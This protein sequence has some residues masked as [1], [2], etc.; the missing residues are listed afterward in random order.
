MPGAASNASS[1]IPSTSTVHIPGIGT[2]QVKL[3]FSRHLVLVKEI[4]KIE[5]QIKNVFILL[6][7]IF[8]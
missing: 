8:L 1:G 4:G 7:H 2:V 3:E 6:C 5:K